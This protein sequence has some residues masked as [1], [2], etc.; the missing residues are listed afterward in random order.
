MNNVYSLL[1]LEPI[2]MEFGYSLIPMAMSLPE[3][4]YQPDCDFSPPVRPEYRLC[5]PFDSPKG[6]LHVSSQPV[7]YRIPGEEVARGEILVDY[8]LA[9]EPESPE[10]EVNGIETIEP[11]YGIPSRWIRPENRERAELYGYT[12]IDPLSVMVTRTFPE[13][14]RQHAFELITRQ[15]VVRLVETLRI[16]APELVDEAFPRI[17]LRLQKKC[18]LGF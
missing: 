4:C 5:D 10:Q 16:S 11:A 9:L 12:V 14:I 3:A 7:L 6:Q 18:F 1:T 2:E 8:F 15:E 17:S 13:V